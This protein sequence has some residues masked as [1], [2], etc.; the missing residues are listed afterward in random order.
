MKPKGPRRKWPTV[1]DLFCGCGGVTAALRAHHFRV[2][3]A[4]DSNPVACASYRK[5]H[6]SVCLYQQDIQTVDPREIRRQH[7]QGTDLDLLVVCS[8][9]QPFSPHNRKGDE[10]DRTTLILSAIRFASALQPT[11]IF[12]ENVPGLTR[13]RF[14]PVL[15]ELKSGLEKL[16]YVLGDPQE[17]DAA[18]YGVPQ[19]RLRCVMLA[20]RGSAP[21]PLP[22]PTT[23]RGGRKTVREAIGSLRSLAAGESCPADV[24][25]F[26]R[27][28]RQIA[29][30]RLRHVPKDGGSRDSLPES[31]W[32][33]CH[34]E[35][36]GHPDVYG[37]MRW[38]DVAPTLTTGCTDVTRGRYAHPDD[39]RAITL[40]E[41]ARLQTFADSYQFAGSAKDIA[42]Q[43][44]NAVPV[45]LIEGLLPAIRAGILMPAATACA[46]ANA[47]RGVN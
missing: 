4:V 42:V 46:T 29:L 23:P 35:H 14:A 43:V 40:R 16:G 13:T 34:R 31:L 2:I 22:E 18:D 1:V 30:E 36:D 6:P 5:N 11:L 3:A 21:P 27:N 19:R 15:A 9:C 7:L 20:R 33:D 12:F 24:L 44:G 41:A 10:D 17:I 38:D 47:P 25:H 37:R 28:H 32:L 8:P 45:R 26:A 39:D